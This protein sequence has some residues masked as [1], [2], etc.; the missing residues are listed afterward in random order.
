VGIQEAGDTKMTDRRICCLTVCTIAF[1]M[2]M[3]ASNQA[4]PQSA[5]DKKMRIKAAN[6][7]RKT[8]NE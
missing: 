7:K 4:I 6:E 3:L 8:D 5:T 2:A 1:G